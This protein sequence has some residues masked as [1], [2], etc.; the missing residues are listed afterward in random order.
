MT[1]VL[2]VDD[3]RDIRLVASMSLSRAGFEVEEAASGDEALD[4]DADAFDAIVLDQRMPGLTGLDTAQALIE[5]GYRGA[6]VLFS[7]Y[8]TPEVEEASAAIGMRTLDKA[9]V[10]ELRTTVEEL[11]GLGD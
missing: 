3:E 5:R 8:L 1:R 7:G 6:L 11:L 9:A 2:V 10:R 4:L